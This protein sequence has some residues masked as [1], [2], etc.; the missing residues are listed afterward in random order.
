MNTQNNT[1]AQPAGQSPSCALPAG[2]ADLLIS[3]T[4][5]RIIIKNAHALLRHKCRKTPL[6]SMVGSI[7]GHGSGYSWEVCVS[8]NLD[9]GQDC[10]VARLKDYKPNAGGQTC[11]ASAPASTCGS[12]PH[13]L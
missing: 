3:G 6:W 12:K 2:S 13:C 9:P 1:N 7:T 4:T 11:G 10:G 5:A 8:A